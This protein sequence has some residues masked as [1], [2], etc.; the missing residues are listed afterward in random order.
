MKKQDLAFL[1]LPACLLLLCLYTSWQLI[2]STWLHGLGLTFL[3]LFRP[4]HTL[5]LTQMA[6]QLSLLPTM[7]TALLAGGLLGAASTLLQQLIKNPLASDT[8]LSVGAGAQLALLMV[9]LFLPS[10]GLY[11]SFWVAF[12]GALASMSLVF[13]LA[14]GSRGNAV[15]LVLAG[16]VVNLLIGAVASLL[17]LFYADRAMGVLLWGAGDITQMGWHT[18]LWLLAGSVLFVLA[19]V[20]LYK[21]L[22]LMGLDDRTAQ[23]LGVPVKQ[24]RQAAIVLIAAAVALVISHLGAIAFVGL[25]AATLTNLLALRTL[26]TRLLFSFGVGGLL[27]WL[28]ANIAALIAPKFSLP[29]PAG[30]ISSLLGVPLI[31]WLIIKSAKHHIDSPTPAL[32]HTQK[33]VNLFFYG[34]LLLGLGATACFV[35]PQVMMTKDAPSVAFGVSHLT[36]LD[37]IAQYRLPR[38]LSA[39]AVGAMLA[40]AGILLQTLTKNPMASPEVLGVS[41]GGAMGVVL[42]FLILPTLGFAV[43]PLHLLPFG[44]MGAMAVLAVILWLTSRV[45]ESLLLLVGVA[46]SAL[47]GVVMSLIGLSGNP[48][49]QAVLS[50]LSGSTYHANP[51]SAWYLL[52]AALVL[53]GVAQLITKPL[54][55]LGLGSVIAQ[56]RGLSVQRFRLGVLTLVALLSAVATL[57]VGPLSFVGLMIPHLASRLG[58]TKLSDSLPLSALLGAIL[59]LVAD[60]LGRYMIFPYEIPAGMLASLIGGAYFVYLMHKTK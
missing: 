1:G 26:G 50:Y 60:W 20:P 57:A 41:S 18:T 13:F 39:M 35:A 3:Q 15:V 44:V 37:F 32:P 29:L 55:L 53:Y 8:T 45:N 49:L 23:S 6:V 2:D 19:L 51:A 12:V 5:S 11:G 42:A 46:I 17:L 58:A 33:P 47:M 9:T 52:G 27:L 31:L 14:K 30:T 34:V 21:P 25:G 22:S 43:T 54:A 10:F 24:I 4:S 59:L 16:L 36:E 38:S 48:K 7:A 40:V 56:G 28:T